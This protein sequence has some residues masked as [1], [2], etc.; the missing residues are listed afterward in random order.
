MSMS[1]G[2]KIWITLAVLFPVAIGVRCIDDG[3]TI[4][5]DIAFTEMLSFFAFSVGRI[6]YFIWAM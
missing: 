3:N 4:L 1:I 6:I 5:S 2:V